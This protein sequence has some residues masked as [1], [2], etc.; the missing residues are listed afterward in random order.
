[1][2]GSEIMK[3][4]QNEDRL[5]ASCEHYGVKTIMK[6]EI[7]VEYDHECNEIWGYEYICPVCGRQER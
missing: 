7:W 1:M 3:K 4:E 5:C 2:W 6:E